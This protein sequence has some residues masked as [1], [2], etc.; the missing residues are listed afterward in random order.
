MNKNLIKVSNLSKSFKGSK[1]KALEQI[2]FS[3]D[4]GEFF[5][6]CGPDAAGKTTLL[7]ILA[8]ILS[9]NEGE[10]KILNKKIPQ[11]ID[12]VQHEIGYMPQKFGLYEDLSVIEN[13]NLNADLRGIHGIEKNQQIDLL[14]EKTNLKNFTKRFASN[15]SGG[16]KQKLALACT[17]ISKPKILLLDEVSVGVDPISRQ[18]LIAIVKDLSAHGTSVIWSTTYLDEAQNADKMLLINEGRQVFFGQPQ[19]FVARTQNRTFL[20]DALDKKSNRRH[21]LNEILQHQDVID[22]VL[23]GNKIRVLQSD[24]DQKKFSQKYD[25]IKVE[26]NIE[27]SFLEVLDAKLPQFSK[28]AASYDQHK[29]TDKIVIEAKNLTKKFGDF[30]ATNNVSFQIKAGTIFGFLGPNGAGKSTTFKMLCGLLKPTSGIAN[31]SGISLLSS[32]NEARQKVGYMAQKFSLYGELNVLQNLNFFCGVYGLNKTQ[33]QKAIDEI[34]NS[35]D[36]KN[37]SKIT[38]TQLPLGIKQ[39]LALGCTLLHKPE[40]LFLDEPTSGVD[41]ATRREFW[42]HIN[43]L[44]QKGVTIIV[45]THFMDEAEYCDIV[46]I[47][48]KGL[49]IA[50][51]DPQKL[52]D[53]I[54]SANL[55]NPSFQDVFIELIKQHD[56]EERL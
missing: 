36:L 32:A 33:A 22:A 49:K 47:I 23:Q 2:N 37:Y 40:V 50:E 20:L 17:L 19:S 52:K 16:M 9:F 8:S 29:K 45:T 54:T 13:L 39:R 1:N 7:R 41:P 14:L 27:D 5:C 10:I 3:V 12:Q 46:A 53:K 34:I 24:N 43:A 35:L 18:E 28:L 4:V 31:V 38:A 56:L 51:D 48:Y 21:N 6:L 11:E 55:P 30:T 42:F 25:V 26:S 44:A 15:L